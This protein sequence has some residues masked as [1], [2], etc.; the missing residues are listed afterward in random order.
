MM[1]TVLVE[2]VDTGSG[3]T[4]EECERL[5]HA[6]LHHEAAWH[7]IGIGGGAIGDQRSWRDD[8]GAERGGSGDYVSDRIADQAGGECGQDGEDGDVRRTA[9]PPVAYVGCPLPSP[10]TR[11]PDSLLRLSATPTAEA[12]ARC[13]SGRGSGAPQT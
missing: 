4:P 6:L 7:G 13:A 9:G 11:V 3:L 1:D 2:I 12:G 5:V 10:V 8:F